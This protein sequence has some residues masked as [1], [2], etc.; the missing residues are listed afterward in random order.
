[1]AGYVPFTY[2]LI[3]ERGDHLIVLYR[4][5]KNRYK[6]YV[7][8]GYTSFDNKVNL[9][10]FV[11][12][13][14]HSKT[15]G[16]SKEF[17]ILPP[18]DPEGWL[19]D[20]SSE[21]GTLSL[22]LAKNDKQRMVD[23]IATVGSFFD[24]T[25]ADTLF[26]SKQAIAQEKL[27]KIVTSN[28]SVSISPFVFS[29]QTLSVL[30]EIVSEDVSPDLKS[31]VLLHLQ[32]ILQVL[33][34]DATSTEDYGRLI[35]ILTN[36]HKVLSNL[37][38][39]EEVSLIEKIMANVLRIFVAEEN[40]L[41]IVGD[42]VDTIGNRG[43]FKTGMGLSLGKNQITIPPMDIGE[44]VVQSDMIAITNRVRNDEDFY[45]VEGLVDQFSRPVEK[46]DIITLELFSVLNANQ[47]Q[48]FNNFSF[49]DLTLQLLDP[50]E[51]VTTS[52]T[53]TRKDIVSSSLEVEPGLDTVFIIDSTGPINITMNDVFYTNLEGKSKITI[54]FQDTDSGSNLGSNI[55]YPFNITTNS[56]QEVT[57]NLQVIH[58]GCAYFDFPTKNWLRD[59]VQ[60][61]PTEEITQKITCR[62][63][64]LT[65]FTGIAIKPPFKLDIEKAL[66]ELDLSENPVAIIMLSIYLAIFFVTFFFVRYMD[67]VDLKWNH[68]VYV[69]GDYDGLDYKYEISIQ[70][71]NGFDAGTSANV[72]VKLYGSKCH[73]T[74]KHLTK[75]IT[76]NQ[77]KLS[78]FSHLFGKMYPSAF[79][80][81]QV[82]VFAVASYEDL[83]DIERIKL[84]H[85]NTGLDPGWFCS[86]VIV[87]NKK[88]N[89]RYY[90][91]VDSWLHISPHDETSS[92]EKLVYGTQENKIFEDSFRNLLDKAKQ[93]TWRDQHLWL[94]IVDKPTMSSFTRVQRLLVAYSSLMIFM[95]F[96]CVWYQS[97]YE[98]VDADLSPNQFKILGI[99]LL[100]TDIIV[101]VVATCCTFP[102]SV[103]LAVLFRS[104]KSKS[105]TSIIP[106]TSIAKMSSQKFKSKF[107]E[108]G[109]NTRPGSTQSL[110]ID[111]QLAKNGNNFGGLGNVINSGNRVSSSGLPGVSDGLSGGPSGGPTTGSS[112]CL[113]QTATQLRRRSRSFLN[114]IEKLKSI[115]EKE[116]K[117]VNEGGGSDSGVQLTNNSNSRSSYIEKEQS[118]ASTLPSIREDEEY[119]SHSNFD[120][121]ENIHYQDGHF[122]VYSDNNS[123]YN[124]SDANFNTPSKGC[125]P[126]WIGYLAFFLV[127]LI[128]STCAFFIILYGQA[129][130]LTRAK[131]WAVTFHVSLLFSFFFL[132][133]V[134]IITF[135]MMIAVTRA[136]RREYIIP[137]KSSDQS[138]LGDLLASSREE[139]TN[140]I[141]TGRMIKPPQGFSASMARKT[142]Y[143]SHR[144][145]KLMNRGFQHVA[146]LVIVF[147]VEYS[148]VDQTEK[149]WL[150]YLE[151][152]VDSVGSVIEEDFS[153]TVQIMPWVEYNQT[154]DR[155]SYNNS[156]NGNYFIFGFDE[157]LVFKNSQQISNKYSTFVNRFMIAH[158]E[159]KN[160]RFSRSISTT[161]STF[162]PSR[163]VTVINLL[164][165][166]VAI[167]T[168]VYLVKF[169]TAVQF[170]FKVE[171]IVLDN[172][173]I[174]NGFNKKSNI[175]FKII[176]RLTVFCLLVTWQVFYIISQVELENAYKNHEI[177]D[178]NFVDAIEAVDKVR[179]TGAIVLSVLLLRCL[180]VFRLFKSTFVILQTMKSQLKVLVHGMGW[181]FL[182]L[183]MAFYSSYY[184][185]KIEP[186]HNTGMSMSNRSTIDNTEPDEVVNSSPAKF[187]NLLY[188]TFFYAI[189]YSVSKV[190]VIR[191]YRIHNRNIKHFRHCR[192]YD[193]ALPGFILN[194][195]LQRLGV[196]QQKRYRHTVKFEGMMTPLSR[197]SSFYGGGGGGFEDV[198][199]MTSYFGEST[200]GA[201]FLDSSTATGATGS[202]NDSNKNS[203]TTKNTL[204]T[205]NSKAS[206]DNTINNTYSQSAKS[207][208]YY[209]DGTSITTDLKS[210]DVSIHEINDQ[211]QSNNVSGSEPRS[212]SD[213]P[214]DTLHVEYLLENVQ[215]YQMDMLNSKIHRID[216]LTRDISDL[217][218]KL[219]RILKT[220]ESISEQSKVE[221]SNTSSSLSF[222]SKNSLVRSRR[223][224]ENETN[225]SQY[226]KNIDLL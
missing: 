19:N 155:K 65:P 173:E 199:G 23:Y 5:P 53:I 168:V 213:K 61:I 93:Y 224:S 160:N 145:K 70:T 215:G 163:G 39:V 136:W 94:S 85:D 113:K 141:F 122:D 165:A 119:Y 6:T 109:K 195:V 129:F 107:N 121:Q 104:L 16:A 203:Q 108:K 210:L 52:F 31:E 164:F 167:Y 73:S 88:T 45:F 28:I 38:A 184:V 67:Y 4:G 142:A 102:F 90:F 133:P 80:R 27:I 69:C 169:L 36:S 127:V 7:P 95:L 10:V 83:G 134:K 191:E 183:F 177:G 194:R 56:P 150:D 128:C 211:N 118:M 125:L 86:K 75:A 1:V 101:A 180:S 197:A 81:G 20:I 179:I 35:N 147:I 77:S 208:S 225:T 98:G 99:P 200:L 29:D 9:T 226:G 42:R 114:D 120:F 216:E 13:I 162:R 54:D 76:V 110:E 139:K 171:K 84:W 25:S 135:S 175:Y 157:N 112:V 97:P 131:R 188:L 89:K 68:L 106:L 209:G 33:E 40:G 174:S 161:S 217:E 82:D 71:G 87:K 198:D 92:V 170:K 55:S 144:W 124:A 111:I 11:E 30:S 176:Y 192:E 22:L 153:Q 172:A 132:E 15:V 137:S 207:S 205:K 3:A 91:I 193:H 156:G 58:L 212:M 17:T 190:T 214:L 117:P 50:V 26:L 204:I 47:V 182:V 63:S 220:K 151:N 49:V 96:T 201:S 24:F 41:E 221:Q 103:L 166:L 44:N 59:G 21:N 140:P 66:R 130:G 51:L 12:D 152:S 178:T 100:W 185:L 138:I 14:N 222:K 64:H 18:S 8:A 206:S 143:R 57:V 223:E 79:K 105:D 2:S 196:K 123:N 48:V 187:F 154:D 32:K 46:T 78:S 115:D 158:V 62:T 37:G 116:K 189:V 126:Y 148:F 146:L 202:N 159:F 34:S 219:M 43:S 149:Y 72:G 181:L 74:S 60:A 186:G 218:E